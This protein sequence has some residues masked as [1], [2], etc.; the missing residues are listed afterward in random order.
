MGLERWYAIRDEAGPRPDQPRIRGLDALVEPDDDGVAEVRLRMDGL[1]CASCVWLVEHVLQADEGVRE[2][3]VSFATGNA[4]LTLNPGARLSDVLAP[5]QDL[6]YRPAP[7]GSAPTRDDGLLLRLG[8]AAFAAINVMLLSVTLYIGWVEPIAPEYETLFRWASLAL[9][10]PIAIWA[11]EPFHKAGVAGLRR[12]VLHLDLPVSIAIIVMFLH[13]VVSTVQGSDTY[14]D[15]L[16]MLV[17]LLLAGRV[18]ERH[19][20]RRVAEAAVSLAAEAPGEARVLRDG[21]LLTLAAGAVEVGDVVELGTGERLVADGVVRSGH[22]SADLSLVTGESEPQALVTGS[23]LP[24]G[25]VLVR[26]GVTVE[27]LRVGDDTLLGQTARTL[28]EAADAPLREKTEK[29]AGW[30]TAG[31]LGAATLALALHGSI[32]PAVAALVA[33]CPCALALAGPLSRAAGLGAAAR[34]GLLLR[35]PRVLKDLADTERV[36]LDKTGTLTHGEPQVGLLDDEVLRLASGLERSSVHPIGKALVRAARDRGLPLPEPERVLEQPGVGIHGVVEGHSVRIGAVLD[37]VVIHVDGVAHPVE[38]RDRIRP[39]TQATVSGLRALG[40]DVGVLSGDRAS[41]ARSVG[42]R[43]GIAQVIGAAT[44][45]EKL[46]GVAKPGTLFVGDGLN[47]AAALAAAP[48]GIA[49]HTGAAPSLLA[50]DGVLVREGIRPLLA[51]VV[52]AR[53]GQAAARRSRRRAVVYN[54]LAVGAALAGLVDPLVAAL[55]MPLSSAMVLWT[56]WRVEHHVD[57]ALSRTGD[58]A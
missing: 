22:G 12:G 29:L 54:V 50:A 11:A 17:A 20:R 44:P 36:W 27:A 30:F 18:V 51:G 38:L 55:A 10:A 25:A 33:A 24:A 28:A 13:G 37:D 3:R 16:V 19:G 32:E 42:D 46:H 43:L 7:L 57:K 15:S 40:I 14:L 21:G 2:A 56:A 45:L 47:D 39:E 35:D 34:R 52:A 9:A 1:R 4:T 6:G 41:I 23:T 53:E 58:R 49:M 8:V 31:T 5:V 26:G 48:V